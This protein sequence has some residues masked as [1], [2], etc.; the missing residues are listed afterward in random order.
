MSKYSLFILAFLF[1]GCAEPRPQNTSL[2]SKKLS[3]LL[4]GALET[5]PYGVKSQNESQKLAKDIFSYTKIL[6]QNFKRTLSPLYHNFLVN[7]NIKDKGLCYHWSDALYLHLNSQKYQ[8][9][10]FHLVGANIGKYWSE[11]NALVII[12]KGKTI[13]EGILLDPWRKLHTLYFV[14]IN[15]DKK[16]QWSHRSKR[17]CLR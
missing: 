11:H 1:L 5:S 6:R 7:I 8:N 10:E 2:E 9:F 15:K 4:E 16:Y 17:G 3:L 14:K 13:E 12:A